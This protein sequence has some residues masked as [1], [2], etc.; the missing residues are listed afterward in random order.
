MYSSVSFFTNGNRLRKKPRRPVPRWPLLWLKPVP[1][2]F[3]EAHGVFSSLWGRELYPV[4][5]AIVASLAERVPS[6]DIATVY[7]AHCWN[8]GYFPVLVITS[9]EDLWIP[10]CNLFSTY[11][12]GHCWVRKVSRLPNSLRTV[13]LIIY[14][15]SGCVFFILSILTFLTC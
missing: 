13:A 3:V 4:L 15:S 1:F 8:L 14:V 11:L 5:V 10:T 7:P 9:G 12:R 6:C 2:T